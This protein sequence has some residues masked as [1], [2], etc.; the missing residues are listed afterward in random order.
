MPEGG[1]GGFS[2]RDE[3]CNQ[4]RYAHDSLEPKWLR[5]AII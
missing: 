1:E 3:V 2:D 5:K 4:S